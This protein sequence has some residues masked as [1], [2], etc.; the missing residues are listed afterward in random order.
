MKFSRSIL[1]AL[2]L[3]LAGTQAASAALEVIVTNFYQNGRRAICKKEK[4]GR[5]SAVESITN[6]NPKVKVA[7]WV[8]QDQFVID[9][10]SVFYECKRDVVNGVEQYYWT[11][12][13]AGRENFHPAQI[14]RDWH[15]GDT[16]SGKYTFDPATGLS[17]SRAGFPIREIL[18]REQLENIRRGGVASAT[19]RWDLLSN[20]WKIP[21][22]CHVLDVTFT[23]DPTGQQSAK[24]ESGTIYQS[25]IDCLNAQQFSVFMRHEPRNKWG[26]PV[27]LP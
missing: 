5:F 8:A 22:V 2:V 4:A 27:R 7:T 21:G 13:A 26:V 16:A 12:R 10:T 19:F 15:I 17:N 23:Q 25:R 9:F 3:T 6:H 20:T 14:N 1:I 11:P 18:S 24:V